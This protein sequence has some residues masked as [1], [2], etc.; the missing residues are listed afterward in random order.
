[1]VSKTAPILGE[2]VA[3]GTGERASILTMS[4]TCVHRKVVLVHK[5]PVTFQAHILLSL[6]PCPDTCKTENTCLLT[7]AYGFGIFNATVTRSLPHYSTFLLKF[8]LILS[9]NLCLGLPKSLFLIGLT[10]FNLW[11]TAPKG[12]LPVDQ[13]SATGWQMAV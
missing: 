1:M 9:S 13:T 12:A 5:L 4:I 2:L 11:L 7:R 8:I 3:V 6:H 10:K